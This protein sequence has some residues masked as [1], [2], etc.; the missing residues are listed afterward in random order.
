M[1][2]DLR[3]YLLYV[4][5][6]RKYTMTKILLSCVKWLG[7]IGIV[8]STDIGSIPIWERKSRSLFALDQRLIWNMLTCIF[9]LAPRVVINKLFFLS[10]NYI[11][12]TK[13]LQVAF[14]FLR[15]A[16]VIEIAQTFYTVITVLGRTL[17]LLVFTVFRMDIN[18]LLVSM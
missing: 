7:F 4:F 13:T 2:C 15:T 6:K 9:M 8:T 16:D 10:Y 5:Q 3:F 12:K 11:I 18:I 1:F 14:M 17:Q